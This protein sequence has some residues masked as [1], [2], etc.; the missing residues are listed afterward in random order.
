M[1]NLLIAIIHALLGKQFLREF[2]VAHSVAY[3]NKR[4]QDIPGDIAYEIVGIDEEVV[5][6]LIAEFRHDPLLFIYWV[7]STNV[8]GTWSIIDNQLLMHNNNKRVLDF[9]ARMCDSDKALQEAQLIRNADKSIEDD[10]F[11][12]ASQILIMD[13]HQFAQRIDYQLTFPGHHINHNKLRA[14]M[15]EHHQEA[16]A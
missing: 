12:S 5:D 7:V 6:D 2:V 11:W 8:Y 13:Y 9:Q 15:A 16:I 14:A 10:D 4:R 1:T 3:L